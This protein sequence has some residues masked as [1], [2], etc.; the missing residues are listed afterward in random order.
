[1]LLSGE[2]GE[3]KVQG[4]SDSTFS[5]FFSLE[6]TRLTETKFHVD[7]PWDGRTKIYSNALGHMTKMASMPIYGKSIKKS[8]S[9][10]PKGR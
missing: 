3:T 6:T 2:K 8:S 1:M 7:H 4:H 10:E 9:L 5:N